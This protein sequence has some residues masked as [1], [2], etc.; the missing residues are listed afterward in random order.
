MPQKC[1]PSQD[2]LTEGARPFVLQEEEAVAKRNLGRAWWAWKVLS[3]KKG[4]GQGRLEECHILWVNFFF[5]N[6]TFVFSVLWWREF[7]FLQKCARLEFGSQKSGQIFSELIE[8]KKF[9]AT[10]GQHE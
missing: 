9:S 2:A 10:L 4:R 1:A 8:M 5:S 3:V 7:L 6:I